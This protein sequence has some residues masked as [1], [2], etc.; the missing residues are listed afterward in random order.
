ME[1]NRQSFDV[2]LSYH[3]ADKPLVLELASRLRDRGLRAW[4]DVWELRPGLSWQD[5][6]ARGLSASKSCAVMIGETGFGAWHRKEVEVALTRHG[7]NY[8]VIPVLLPGAPDRVTG[9]PPALNQSEPD[10]MNAA[11]FLGLMTWVDFTRGL[12]DSAAFDRLVWG[13]TGL[14]R[15]HNNAPV[16]SE[17]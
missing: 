10:R 2:F 12:D 15:D 4:V 14:R 11:T 16:Q 8:P 7:Y 1:Q 9:V 17:P 13:I 3:S 6:L 5:G